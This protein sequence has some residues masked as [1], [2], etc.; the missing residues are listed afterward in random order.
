MSCILWI[1]Q[2]LLYNDVFFSSDSTFIVI[3][4]KAFLNGFDPEMSMNVSYRGFHALTNLTAAIQSLNDTVFQLCFTSK[5]INVVVH[6]LM[7][8]LTVRAHMRTYEKRSNATDCGGQ[9]DAFQIEDCSK[10]CYKVLNRPMT[11]RKAETLCK[12]QYFF[13]K[14]FYLKELCE[15]FMLFIIAADIDSEF[16]W[17][18]LIND[19]NT[20]LQWSNSDSN[21]Y[22]FS[23]VKFTPLSSQFA[24]SINS[25]DIVDASYRYLEIP[26]I[27][28]NEPR[29]WKIGSTYHLTSA[30]YK[31]LTN[32]KNVHKLFIY[33]YMHLFKC[34]KVLNKFL[35]L[36]NYRWN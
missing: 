9:L 29:N 10:I 4:L 24:G 16:F 13:S 14:L 12:N 23:R 8:V 34:Y 11:R 22:G 2:F 17:I 25:Y 28:R 1:N 33:M 27:C 15:Q 7:L 26:A 36:W 32:L 19:N 21:T 5:M 20:G 31:S 35:Y 30:C 18:G 6:L 3:L